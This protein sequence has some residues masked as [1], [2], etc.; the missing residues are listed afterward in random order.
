MAH[1]FRAASKVTLRSGRDITPVDFLRGTFLH[2]LRDVDGHDAVDVRFCRV[3]GLI[4]L[5]VTQLI[6]MVPWFSRFVDANLA[7][8]GRIELAHQ[9]VEYGRDSRGVDQICHHRIIPQVFTFSRRS[10]NSGQC[11][12][13]QIVRHGVLNNDVSVPVQ[14]ALL[15]DV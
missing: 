5:V 9:I 12:R 3:V 1:D 13:D 8:A 6:E 7:M 11:A 14:D 4:L 15:F 2:G 10:F